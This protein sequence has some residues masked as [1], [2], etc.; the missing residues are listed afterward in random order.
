MGSRTSPQDNPQGRRR[1]HSSNLAGVGVAGR[2]PSEVEVLVGHNIAGF[3]AGFGAGA[4]G[5]RYGKPLQESLVNNPFLSSSSMSR[6]QA[7]SSEEE[8]RN[9]ASLS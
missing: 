5:E 4:N 6:V 9:T 8:P 3:G 1:G 2:K 7:E